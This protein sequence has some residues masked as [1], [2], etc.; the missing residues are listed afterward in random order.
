M[1]INILVENINRELGNA[2]RNS[3]ERKILS[4]YKIIKTKK[5][6]FVIILETVA[7]N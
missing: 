4:T 3:Y 5:A 6:E 1:P 2:I 7:N